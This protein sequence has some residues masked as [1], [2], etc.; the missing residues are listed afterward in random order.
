MGGAPRDRANAA[1]FSAHGDDVF[2]RIA[3]RYDLMCDLF[4]LGIHRHWKSRVARHIAEENWTRL[5][6]AASGTGDVVL[7]GAG[8]NPPRN[9]KLIVSSDLCPQMRA[10]AR[11]RAAARNAVF[12]F[13]LLDVHSMPE[14]ADASF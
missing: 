7:R 4:S 12:E 3:G 13:R 9:E 6:D 11:R 1:A 10:V 14:I 5:L 2:S 8:G